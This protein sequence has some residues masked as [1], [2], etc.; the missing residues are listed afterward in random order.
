MLPLHPGCVSVTR[1]PLVCGVKS[2]YSHEFFSHVTLTILPAEY[3]T[4]NVRESP[5]VITTTAPDLWT[6]CPECGAPAPTIALLTSYTVYLRCTHC[7]A[8]WQ[9]PG[10]AAAVAGPAVVP[11]TAP[12][13]QTTDICDD[14]P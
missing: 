11:H 3:A 10:A 1:L 7:N 4:F 14:L 5:V 6:A 12:L 2:S 13:A 8:S 9:L